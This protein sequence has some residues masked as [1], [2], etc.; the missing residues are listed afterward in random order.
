MLTST[1][2]TLWLTITEAQDNPWRKTLNPQDQDINIPSNYRHG[3]IDDF[4]N[5]EKTTPS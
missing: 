4:E 1:K 2:P 3:D 5:V